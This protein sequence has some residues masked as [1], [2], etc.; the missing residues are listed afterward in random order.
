MVRLRRPGLVTPRLCTASQWLCV[1]VERLCAFG[2]PK[3]ILFRLEEPHSRD[4]G[5]QVH[6]K[7]ASPDV[8]S[9]ART[10]FAP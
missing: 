6:T 2:G 1:P 7:C 10:L 5:A 4:E 3:H 9:M 8:V